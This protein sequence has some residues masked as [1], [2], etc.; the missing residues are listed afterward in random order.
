M[1]PDRPARGRL[2]RESLEAAFTSGR[3][4]GSG[5]AVSAEHLWRAVRGE[6]PPA[7]LQALL[8]RMARCPAAAEEWRLARAL[9]AQAE[10]AAPGVRPEGPSR[11]RWIARAAALAAVFALAAFGLRLAS[12]PPAPVEAPIYRAQPTAD[13]HAL[14]EESVPLSRDEPVL[15]WTPSVAGAR[16]QVVLAREDGEVLAELGPTDEPRVRVPAEVLEAI[17]RGGVLLW[18]VRAW[19]PDGAASSSITFRQRVE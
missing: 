16:Y 8:D 1:S 9:A 4:E 12:L 11:P 17:P 10:D 14:I 7:E 2:G 18:R 3:P 5:P 6:L 15:A 19:R 13:L